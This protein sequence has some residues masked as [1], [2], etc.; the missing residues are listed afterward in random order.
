MRRRF[1]VLANA[2]AAPY[3]DCTSVANTHLF[4][5][6]RAAACAVSRRAR[7]LPFIRD[8]V[9]LTKPRITLLVLLTSA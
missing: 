8:L 3:T 9:M 4:G 1:A 7:V 2:Q 5:V 6:D